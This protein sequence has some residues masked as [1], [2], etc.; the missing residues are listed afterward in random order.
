MRLFLLSSDTF[1]PIIDKFT[2]TI[3]IL[4]ILISRDQM[5]PPKEDLKLKKLAILQK[6]AES[7]GFTEEY[8]QELINKE[9]VVS[10]KKRSP[11]T[12]E[13]YKRAVENWRM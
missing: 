13:R 7:R 2:L 1:K 10:R 6:F 5:A 4:P 8:Q 11:A 12:D 3:Y 9:N